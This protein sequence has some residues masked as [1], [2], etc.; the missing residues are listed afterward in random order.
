MSKKVVVVLGAHRSG[1]SLVASSLETM[2]FS[3]GDSLMPAGEDNPKGFFEDLDIVGINDALLCELGSSWDIPALFYRHQSLSYPREYVVSAAKLLKQKTSTHK[4]FALKD[5]RICLLVPFWNAVFRELDIDVKYVFVYRNPLEVAS[6]LFERDNIPIRTGAELWL[7]YCLEALRS[8]ESEC[9][10]VAYESVLEQP[11]EQLDQLAEYLSDIVPPKPVYGKERNGVVDNGLRHSNYDLEDLSSSPEISSEVLELYQLLISK[12]RVDLSAYSSRIAEIYNSAI[13]SKFGF[14]FLLQ[15]QGRLQQKNAI[16]EATLSE[17]DHSIQSL[18]DEFD[19]RSTWANE[20]S[21]EIEAARVMLLKR[22]KELEEK[23]DWALSLSDQLEEKTAWAIKSAAEVEEN[24]HQILALNS[25]V[26]EKLAESERL[27]AELER[28]GRVVEELDSTVDLLRDEVVIRDQQLREYDRLHRD[29]LSSVSFRLGRILTWPV[30]GIISLVVLPSIE[31]SP[32]AAAV[33]SLSRNAIASPV[34]FVKLISAERIK[35]FYN[36]LFKRQDLIA[37]ITHRYSETLS[38][39]STPVTPATADA[40]GADDYEGIEL[41]FIKHSEPKVSVIIPVHNQLEYTLNCLKSIRANLP[42]VSFEII[43]ADD[44]SSDLTA[45]V[46]SNI[47]GISYLRNEENMGFLL[48][49]NKAVD[50]AVGEYVF[51]LNNDTRVTEGWLDELMEVFLARPDAGLVGS[52]LVY[53]DGRLQEAGGIIWNDASG[54]NYGRLDDP[55]KPEYNYLKEVDYVSGAAILFPR[56][57]FLDAGKFDERYVP[58]YYEDTDLAF[59]IRSIGKKVYY[60]PRSVVVHYEGVSNGQDIAQGVKKHQVE[61][62]VKFR[63]KWQSVL[64]QEHCANAEAVFLSRDRSLRKIT[65]LVV[66][67]YVPHFDKDAGSRSTY[68]YIRLMVDNGYNVKFIGD[69]FY[70]HEPYSTVLESLGVELLLG[71]YYQQNWKSW[72]SDNAQYIDIAYLHRPHIAEKYIDYIL[73]LKASIKII[74]FGCDLHYLRA[75]RQYALEGGDNLKREI[76]TWHDREWSLFGKADTVLYPSEAEVSEIKKED[77]EVKAIAIPLYVLDVV[78][79]EISK[80]EPLLLF[81]GGFNHPPNVDAVN[82]FVEEIWPLVKSEVADATFHIVGSNTPDDI[83]ALADEDVHIHGFLSDDEL[84]E[85][86]DKA[87]ISIAPLRFGAGIKGKILGSMAHGVPVV[88]TSIGA[89]GIPCS[90]HCMGIADDSVNFARE[91][92]RVCQSPQIQSDY[93]TKSYETLKQ[94]FSSQTVTRVLESEFVV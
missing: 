1:T 53:P 40:L 34:R 63:E 48:T 27:S 47:S 10:F 45:Q 17:K 58:A 22:D 28:S 51:L 82:W 72:L 64:Q 52:K 70:R 59:T 88:T 12:Q 74:Y 68:Q 18:Q 61:N 26:Q 65:I 31:H 29:M 23:T 86:Y 30:R 20:L 71:N 60:Q 56:Q 69:N 49:C 13:N 54:W 32:K 39:G 79:K 50:S 77:A 35:N 3:L 76:K 43:V 80:K 6:S 89:E 41:S 55:E 92:I 7:M 33:L 19:K 38:H 46:I 73:S 5:P 4:N 90:E 11:G 81:V 16:L 36:L 93:I 66:D 94:N 44:C 25:Q 85:L 24:R 75:R 62:A 9:Y 14:E 57:V 87:L 84:E 91:V 37:Q 8:I 83:C 67:H 21:E 42:Q 2:G 15:Q 78:E